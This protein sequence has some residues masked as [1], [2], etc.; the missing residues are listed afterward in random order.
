MI[1]ISADPYNII[2]VKEPE[3][4]FVESELTT[5]RDL[6]LKQLPKLLKEDDRMF[7]REFN[8][9]S[10]CV[11]S[12]NTSILSRMVL[13]SLSIDIEYYFYL[14]TSATSLILYQT[15]IHLSLPSFTIDVTKIT[16]LL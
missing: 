11:S 6:A 12:I 7:F 10:L 2:I 4:S 5:N 8:V 16:T 9:S 15:T 3:A 13:D 14:R 1:K